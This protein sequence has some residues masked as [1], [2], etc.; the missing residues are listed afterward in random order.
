MNQRNAFSI[1]PR[2]TPVRCASAPVGDALRTARWL[3][4]VTDDPTDG[5]DSA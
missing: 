1:M 2:R 4:Q 3:P 5:E